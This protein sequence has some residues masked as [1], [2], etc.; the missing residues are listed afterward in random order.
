[1]DTLNPQQRAAVEHVGTPLLVLAGAGSG[2]TRVITEKIAF[3]IREHGIDARNIAAI[4]FTN[5]AASEMQSRIG[6]LLSADAAKGLQASTFHT[7]GLRIIRQELETLGYKPGFSIF[8]AQDSGQ[9]LKELARKEN[10]ESADS[11]Q[12]RISA[13]KNDFISPDQAFS[14]AE[15]NEAAFHAQLYERYQRQLKAY[16]AVDFDDLI[17]LPVKLFDEF[18]AIREKWQNRL[19]YLLVD[20]YQDTNACQYR[21]VKLLAGVEGRLTAVGDDDQSIYAWRGARPENLN[22]L[23][24]DFPMLEVIMLEQN[25]RSTS[26]ILQSANTLIANNPHV[27]EKQLWSTLGEG[28]P[29]RVI[30]CDSAEHEAERIVSEIMNIKFKKRVDYNQFAILYRGNFQSRLFER[31]LREHDIPYFVSGGTSFFERAEIKDIIGYLRLITNPDDDA[32]FLRTVNTPRREI[33]ASTLEKLGKY[34]TER[35]ISLLTASGELG[36]EPLL[37]QRALLRLQRFAD[38][39]SEFSYRAEDAPATP[40]VKSLLLELAYEDWLREISSNDRIADKRIENVAELLDWIS[41]L[42][43]KKTTHTSLKDIVNR[44]QLMDILERNNDDEHKKGVQMMTLHAAKGLEFPHVFIVGM[45]EELLPHK[46]SIEE[47]NL[48][49]E[50]RLAYVGITRARQTLTMTYARKRQKYGEETECE[51]SR[52]L[53]ELPAEHLD[54]DDPNSEN[55]ER[56]RETGRNHLKHLKALLG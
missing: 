17:V 15:D 4:T 50:R 25:Y 30:P 12:W 39:I 1:M 5:K 27:F 56:S 33:G 29:L 45:E 34:A 42:S 11:I 47:D 26:R 22:L 43:A 28:D 35:N 24:K 21:L 46:T 10:I 55:E 48:E 31:K 23:K 49:E 19:R 8:D 14:T 20:E 44:M 2:K 7:L 41:R 6:K 18:P 40:L 37:S 52:F 38:Q 36:L 13:W 32:A 3:L 53:E 16:N 54:W 51:P 9:L